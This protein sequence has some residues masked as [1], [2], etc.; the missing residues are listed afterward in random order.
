MKKQRELPT[1]AIHAGEIRPR[2]AGAVSLPIFQSATFE[3]TPGSG[4][5]DLGYIR[6]NNTPN[7]DSLHAK[8]AALEGAEAG[9]VAASGMAA[10]TTSLLT[11]LGAGD[12]LLAQDSLYGGTQDFL[13]EDLPQLG[14]EVTYIDAAKP[15]TWADLVQPNTR[16]V[17]AEAITNPLVRIGDLH[18][19]ASFARQHSLLSMIDSTFASPVNL[20]PLALGFDLVLHSATKYLNGHS[21]IVAGALAGNA[22]LVEKIQRKLNHLGGC[23]DPHACFLLHRGIKTLTLRVAQ[24][25][26]S[27]LALAERLEAHPAVSQVHYPGLPSHPDH[28]RAAELLEGFG[29]MMSME[30][31]AT[32]AAIDQQL[33]DLE[34]MAFAPSLG[35]VETLITR[36]AET[37]HAGMTQAQRLAAGISDSL[38]RIS[39]GC[40]AVDDLWADLKPKIDAL[41]VAA[42]PEE[43]LTA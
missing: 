22:P 32:G 34:V 15:E 10:I 14:V 4:Y 31:R 43:E 1:A 27:A 35:G 5:H 20:L 11:V 39:V 30:L 36:P 2:I 13:T 37:S 6:L 17:Y 16:V 8:I 21:D 24:Q 28:G 38:V 26:R 40:E 3:S 25:N 12:H 33:R 7:H 29:G 41:A 23:L 19:L 42:A 9:L 18:A